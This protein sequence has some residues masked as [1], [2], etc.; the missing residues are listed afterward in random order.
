LWSSYTEKSEPITLP[1]DTSKSEIVD[2][3]KI[4]SKSDPSLK[5]SLVFDE[6]GKKMLRDPK[7]MPLCDE[8]LSKECKP[9]EEPSNLN[10]SLISKEDMKQKKMVNESI[11]SRKNIRKH[12]ILE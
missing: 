3:H 4:S 5:E 2:R 7:S 10:D 9:S 8:C 6:L 1:T 12:M 11:I